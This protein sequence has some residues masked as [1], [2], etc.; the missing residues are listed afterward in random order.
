LENTTGVHRRQPIKV[1]RKRITDLGR[2]KRGDHIAWHRWYAVWHHAIVID[3]DR[4]KRQLTV[5]HNSG[6]PKKL[7]GKLASVRLEILDVD[8]VKEDL[9]LL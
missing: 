5:I 8:P 9:Y 3:V 2:L 7:D 6:A 1:R 4:V